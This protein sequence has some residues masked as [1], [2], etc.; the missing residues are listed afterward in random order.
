MAK[1]K[2]KKENTDLARLK[3]LQD[4]L[5]EIQDKWSAMTPEEQKIVAETKT[6]INQY[7]N[8]SQQKEL[9]SMFKLKK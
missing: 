4:R 6:E 8:L 5:K 2:V 9:M 1:K 7:Q 3:V